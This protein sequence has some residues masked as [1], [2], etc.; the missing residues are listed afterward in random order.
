VQFLETTHRTVAYTDAFCAFQEP[1]AAGGYTVARRTVPNSIDWDA[2][3]ILYQNFVPVLCLMH[4]RTCLITVGGFDES[5]TTHEDWD[6]CIRLSQR[7]EMAHVKKVTCEFRQRS[8]A[9]SMTGAQFPDFGRT[10]KLIHEKYSG[11]AE[12]KPHVLKRQC[13]ILATFPLCDRL[14]NRPLPN[15]LVGKLIGK[16]LRRSVRKRLATVSQWFDD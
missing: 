16:K 13:E 7:Y 2:D 1:L 11:L 5:L 3:R 9:T 15:R 10:M 6:L 8:D 4:K 14:D 12:G